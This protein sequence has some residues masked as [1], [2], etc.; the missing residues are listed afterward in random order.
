[1]GR[2]MMCRILAVSV[3]LLVALLTTTSGAAEQPNIVL[4]L[5]DDVGYT[6]IGP[7]GSE[8]NTPTLSALAQRGIRFS[9][10]HTAASCAPSRAM[11]LTGVDSHRNGVPNI[12]EALPPE[13]REHPHY[14]GE[15][16]DNVV[17]VATL[18]RRMGYHTYLTGKWHLGKSPGTLP[19]QRGF[20]R[21]VA[22]MDTGADNWEQKPYLPIYE[23]ANWFADGEP[24]QLPDDFYSSRFLIDKA[25]EF[26]DG[27][28]GDA[29]PFF[30]YVPFMAVHIPVQAPQQFIDRYEGV[31]HKGWPVLRRQRRAAAID[32]GLVPADSGMVDM[33]STD[34]WDGLSEEQQR[35]NAKRMAVYAGMVEAMDYH[36]GRLV[37]YLEATDQLHNTVFIF[38]SDNGA[39]PTGSAQPRS[40][41]SRLALDRMGYENAYETLGLKGSFNSIGASFASAAVGPLAYY[42]FYAG[43]GGMRVPLI[44]SGSTISPQQGLTD[45]FAYVTD[46]APTIIELAGGKLPGAQLGDRAVEPMVGRSLMGLIH[47]RVER[48]YGDE[49]PV[50]YEL[51]GNAALFQG[52]YKIMMNRAPLGDGRW[53]LYDIARDPGE[54]VDLSQTQ[55]ERFERM[56]SMYQAY[57]REN[58]VLPVPEGYE[59][60]RQIALNGLADRWG[61]PLTVVLLLVVALVLIW[62][63]V[64]PLS[65]L[66]R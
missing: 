64:R 50:G 47:G 31:Y 66:H 49:D 52:N 9:N 15:L 44:V 54:T 61:A 3:G 53:H 17:T 39:E 13:Q 56:L 20:E 41:A 55:P 23:K 12:P 35:Y 11:L 36:I 32:L 43:E 6:D 1:M 42:K 10:Y 8:I 38:T 48:V 65:R 51:A 29:Q 2:R 21:T 37:A 60:L 4:I 5:A 27:N 26:I 34:D 19:S 62:R 46:I 22:M 40:L 24:L 33:A 18:L 28:R 25:I 63:R 59:Q 57:A 45:A 30:A 14:K 16:T 58:G 7:Y